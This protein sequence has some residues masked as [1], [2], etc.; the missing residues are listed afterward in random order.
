M[1][2]LTDQ[3]PLCF[4]FCTGNTKYQWWIQ[5]HN[6]RD[7]DLFK[8]SRPR[9]HQ[10]F[11]DRD[12]RLKIRDRGFQICGFRQ[13]V[14]KNA[15]TTSTV[16]LYFDFLAFSDLFSLFLTCKYN[17]EKIVELQKFY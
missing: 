8:T 9:L 15:A 7:R 16:Q 6:L 4:C 2:Y 10:K 11:R 1:K 17:K 3:F 12:S 13:N 14:S 5:E